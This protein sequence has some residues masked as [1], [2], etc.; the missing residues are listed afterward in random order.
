MD[1]FPV[2]V[3][4]YHGPLDLLLILARQGE[5][6]ILDLAIAEITRRYIDHPESGRHWDLEDAGEFLV[7]IASL[8]ELKSHRLVPHNPQ[9]Q[10]EVELDHTRQELVKQL[11]EYRKFR[12]AASLLAERADRQRLRLARQVDELGESARDPSRQPIRELE[13]WDLVSAFSRLMKENVV[14]AAEE[15]ER[16]PTPLPVYMNRLEAAVA[17][18][19]ERGFTLATL[20]GSR[21]TKAQLIGKFLALLE[22]IKSGRVWAEWDARTDDILLF[23]PSKRPEMP[24]STM[25]MADESVPPDAG[26]R[27]P[28]APSPESNDDPWAG[29]EPVE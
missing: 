14:P 20:F 10:P 16:D 6:D 13:L 8:M 9:S 2:D 19:P 1:D 21:N 5:I 11:L 22:L 24:Q 3:D 28:T 4:F 7:I 12:E 25:T 29:Y 15:V 17:S 18:R 27:E 26:W 23:A